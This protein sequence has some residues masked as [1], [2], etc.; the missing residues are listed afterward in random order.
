MKKILIISFA[1]FFIPFYVFIALMNTYLSRVYYT[2]ILAHSALLIV[3]C[4]TA[5]SISYFYYI[6]YAKNKDLL[7]FIIALFFKIIGLAMFFHAITIPTFYFMN[8]HIF[9]VTEHFGLFLASLI[10]MALFLPV[11]YA[12]DFIYNNKRKILVFCALTMILGFISLLF[13]IG[14]T[15]KFYKD[16]NDFIFLSGV[17]LLVGA[18]GF[19]KKR[20]RMAEYVS[21]P[22]LIAG[23]TVLVN[24]AIIPFFYKEWNV[25]WWYFHIVIFLAEIVIFIGILKK[26]DKKHNGKF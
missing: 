2:N 25:V 17:L 4:S 11:N 10:L 15:D 3:I 26:C 23:L 8:E 20:A 24:A 5:F 22:Y 18:I 13:S 12:G 9:D 6:N 21:F 16:V 19:L 7:F 1:S 14:L